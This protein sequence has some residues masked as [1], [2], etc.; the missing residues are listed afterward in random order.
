MVDPVLTEKQREEKIIQVFDLC[1]F[2]NCYK[3]SLKIVDCSRHKISIVEDNGIRKGIYFCDLIYNTRYFFDELLYKSFTIEAFKEQ[4]KVEELWFVV[5]EE[6]FTAN[7]FTES[8]DFIKRNNVIAL[9][10]KVFHCNFSQSVIK[11]LK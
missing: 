2:I 1:H 9:Y 11:I 3:R 8:A 5:V 10:D 7:H 4:C 6:S